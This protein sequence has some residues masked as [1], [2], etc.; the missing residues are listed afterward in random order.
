MSSSFLKE[1][2]YKKEALKEVVDQM[3]D[4]NLQ[5]SN[6]E[7]NVINAGYERAAAVSKIPELE[8]ALQSCR[9]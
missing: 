2:S 6:C 9:R 1:V 5:L 4:A 3:V 8:Q 7:G